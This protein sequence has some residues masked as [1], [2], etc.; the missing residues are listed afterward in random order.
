[1][2]ACSQAKAELKEVK[3]KESASQGLAKVEPERLQQLEA[4]TGTTHMHRRSP[5]AAADLNVGGGIQPR[6]RQSALRGRRSGRSSSALGKTCKSSWR[7][8][9]QS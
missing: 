7:K 9:R 6:W 2:V 5:A 4:D 3:A 1:M 8:P